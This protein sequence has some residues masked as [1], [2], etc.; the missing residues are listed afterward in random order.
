MLIR[1]PAI[2]LT[3]AAAEGVPHIRQ[4]LLPSADITRCMIMLPSAS[5]SYPI[6]FK[7]D[8]M[9]LSTFSKTALTDALSQPVLIIEREVRSPSTAFIES[10]TI[11]FPA[12]VSPVST[13][14]PLKNSISACSIT[15]ML[16]IVKNFSIS[17]PQKC[18]MYITFTKFSRL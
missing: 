1:C 4:L 2:S 14:N 13:L 9:L 7:D 18:V 15:A 12:P 11:D 17:S 3:V 6:S 5:G 10:I 16:L 8:I